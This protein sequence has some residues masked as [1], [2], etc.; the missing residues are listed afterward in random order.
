MEELKEFG[1][2]DNEIKIYLALLKFGNLN[3]SEIAQKTGFSRSYVYDALERLMEKGVVSTSLIKNKKQ[4]MAIDPKKLGES[5][6]QKLEKLQKIIPQLEQLR[7]S[8]KEDIKVELHKGTYIYKILLN[9]IISTLKKNNEVLI[10]GVDDEALMKLDK[11]Y[12]TNLDIY[13]SKLEKLNIKEKVIA[14]NKSKMLK[15]A[16]TTSYRFLPKQVIG[17][18]AFQVYGN[19]VGIFLWGNPNYL[20]LIENMEIADSYRNQF[21]IL[22]DNAKR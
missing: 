8:S 5:L 18:T 10:F 16:K 7:E 2:T 6:K 4:F 21:K 20:I 12:K 1:L 19:K 22:W 15:G 13:F 14:N 11:H 3:P 9:D 17:N